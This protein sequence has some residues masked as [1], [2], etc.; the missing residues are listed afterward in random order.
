MIGNRKISA[1]FLLVTLFVASSDALLVW[2][3]Y[4]AA[5]QT[6]LQNL[7]QR[8]KQLHD[9]YLLTLEQTA[10]F[11][12]QTATY[13]ANDERVNS[14]FLAG[15]RAVEAEGGGA[16]GVQADAI[17]RDLHQL[18]SSG[19]GEMTR[20]YKGRQ[21]HFHLPPDTSFLRVHRP[22]KYGDDLSPIRH[23]IVAANTGLKGTEGF[24]SGRVYA[25]IR[26]V[27][28]VFA[29][30]ANGERIHVGAL[31]AGTSFSLML[32]QLKGVLAA[33]YAVLMTLEHA[34]Q[35]MWPDFLQEY[36]KDHPVIDGHMLEASTNN[37]QSRRILGDP[38][39]MTLLGTPGTVLAKIDDREIAVTSFPL[40]DYLGSV[41]PDRKD[42][43][44]ILVWTP[45]EAEIAAFDA[46]IR[47]NLA[48]AI[49]GFILIETLIILALRIDRQL[50]SH[51]RLS[52]TDGLTGVANRRHFDQRVEEEVGRARRSSDNLAIILCDI[53]YFKQYNDHY[54]HTAGDQ[55][56]RRVAD[57]LQNQLR[58]SGELLARYGGEEFVVVLP[59]ADS[60]QGAVVAE[61]LRRGVEAMAI[62]HEISEAADYVTISCGVSSLRFDPGNADIDGFYLLSQAD[63]ALYA[64]KEAG[65]NRVTTIDLNPATAR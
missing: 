48:I 56:L 5:K 62:A 41:D 20:H 10:S 8:G 22:D 65:R 14:L 63:K 64:A 38:T 13:I 28:P 16:G 37:R 17:R 45:A 34:K 53:D 23:S 25:G 52:L 47:T 1:A 3:N 32:K 30:D 59:G 6:M 2:V 43:G 21:L 39:V 42:I 19:W 24:E 18:V 44:T 27:V 33:E 35:T 40:R 54:G 55:C 50:K 46:G 58:R 49:I 12:R 4:R 15:R 51:R 61:R 26:G 31:E 11:M 57:G 60:H 7:A 9:A 36:I 29:R